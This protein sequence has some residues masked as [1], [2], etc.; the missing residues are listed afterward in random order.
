MII[1]IVNDKSMFLENMEINLDVAIE[2][3]LNF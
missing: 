1:E 2:D 3:Y